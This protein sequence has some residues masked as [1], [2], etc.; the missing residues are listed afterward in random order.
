[1]K[2]CAIADAPTLHHETRDFAPKEAYSRSYRRPTFGFLSATK[3]E[4]DI[5]D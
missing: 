4:S 1:M 2:R 5:A 3:S